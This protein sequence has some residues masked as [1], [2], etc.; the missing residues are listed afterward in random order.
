MRSLKNQTLPFS[1]KTSSPKTTAQADASLIRVTRL[2][3]IL[4]LLH[5]RLPGHR[6]DADML[7]IECHCDTRTIHRDLNLLRKGASVP[8]TYCRPEK[9]YVLA[10][11]DWT[12]PIAPLTGEDILALSLLRGLTQRPDLPAA[13]AVR[14]VL[15]KVTSALSPALRRLLAESSQAL[16]I[17]TG[18]RDYSQAPLEPLRQAITDQEILRMDYDSRSGGKRTWRLLNPY[19]IAVSKEQRWMVHGWC[20]ENKAFRTF[21]LDKIL[22]V[23]RTGDRFL[24]D[25]VGWAEFDGMTGIVGGLRG[26]SIIS[27]EAIF[28]PEVA[29]YLDKGWPETLTLV[30]EPDGS[31]RLMGTVL[32]TEGIVTELLRWRRHCFVVGG[33]ELRAAMEEEI[34]VMAGLYGL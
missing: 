5:S 1:E 23:Q 31:V 13:E 14:R 33:P 3:K 22:G 29:A 16:R 26:A 11:A 25:E 8:I 34:T 4:S 17:D 28:A 20:H 24:R 15:D 30:Q 12:F 10:E 18:P 21:S 19:A 7:S 32:G 6:L 27:V 2:V 9:A